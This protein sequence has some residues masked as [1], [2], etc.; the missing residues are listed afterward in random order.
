MSGVGGTV[1]EACVS[2][3]QSGDYGMVQRCL[4]P[5]HLAEGADLEDFADAEEDAAELAA[6]L[7]GRAL[8][9]DHGDGR[10]RGGAAAVVVRL[11]A[12][13]AREDP[14]LGVGLGTE[15]RRDVRVERPA[16]G[17]LAVGIEDLL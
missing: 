15:A 7:G 16:L 5:L 10:A 4:A 12:V 17:A 1:P 3:F 2:H 9:A 14:R 8:A 11:D 13:L 6:L